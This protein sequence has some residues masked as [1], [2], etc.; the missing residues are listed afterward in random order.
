M[1]SD[2]SEIAQAKLEFNGAEHTA[3]PNSASWV[4][5]RQN[6]DLFPCPVKTEVGD[7]L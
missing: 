2:L 3:R 5:K 4:A 7:E 1:L 6:E